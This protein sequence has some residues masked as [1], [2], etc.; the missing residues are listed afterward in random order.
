MQLDEVLADLWAE[1]AELDR[2]VGGLRADAWA[3]PTPAEGWTIAHQIAHLAWTDEAARP[4]RTDP[5]ASRPRC[6]QAAANPAGYVDEGAAE[7]ASLP[8]G[9]LLTYWRET[10]G[11]MAEALRAVPAGEKVPWFGPPMS[12]T[13]MAT[14]R[15]METWAHGQD[16]ADALGVTRQ[17]SQPAAARRAPRGPHPRLRLPAERP[18]PTEPSRSTWNSR[19]PD[20]ET[21]TWGPDDAEQRVTASG[22]RLLPAGD[23]T[24]AS[25]RPRRTAPKEQAEEWLGIIQAFAVSGQ[26]PRAR[27]VRMTAAWEA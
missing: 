22:A 27:A 23:P 3:T 11:E 25:R 15:L 14:A 1:S 20:G 7:T 4:G 12:P 19:G 24:P 8:P 10:R 21:W 9:Q 16:V 26:G 5:E 18:H 6:E 17:P 13:S 2:L